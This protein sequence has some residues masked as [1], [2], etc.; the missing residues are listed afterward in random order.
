[1]NNK[2]VRTHSD[3]RLTTYSVLFIEFVYKAN[4]NNNNG[5]MYKKK[6]PETC[7]F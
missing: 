3:S 6:V 2:F 7:A 4:N 5:T 1:M